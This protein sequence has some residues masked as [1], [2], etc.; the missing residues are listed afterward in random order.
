MTPFKQFVTLRP[1]RAVPSLV[2]GSL[3]QVFLS[4]LFFLIVSFDTDM[5]PMSIPAGIL[6]PRVAGSYE[7]I[8]AIRVE[9]SK[10]GFSIE[11]VGIELE[12]DKRG[13][14]TDDS[15]RQ[16]AAA[17]IRARQQHPDHDS[18]LLVADGR[19]PFQMFDPLLKSAEAA[20]ITKWSLVVAG[21]P[22]NEAGGIK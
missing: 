13:K 4:L 20:G 6:I 19:L 5:T 21:D 16:M 1:R 2:T 15:V 9:A 3:V 8:E 22:K 17:L 11:G 12:R 14:V 7:P 18:L 10:E